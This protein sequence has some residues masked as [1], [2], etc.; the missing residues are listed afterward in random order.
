MLTRGSADSLSRIR[1][2][3][4]HSPPSLVTA[5]LT[6]RRS[7]FRRGGCCCVERGCGG[8]AEVRCSCANGED[9]CGEGAAGARRVAGAVVV[10][11]RWCS[12]REDGGVL[13]VKWLNARGKKEMASRWWRCG[14]ENDGGG[15]MR[16]GTAQVALAMYLWLPWICVCGARQHFPTKRTAGR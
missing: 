14:R 15:W 12:A 10:C 4:S 11:S 9:G 5:R 6:V 16:D 13:R 8:V 2:S 3:L 1:V 7:D